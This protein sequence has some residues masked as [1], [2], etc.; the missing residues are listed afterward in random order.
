[1]I[2]FLN[3]Q[4]CI[5]QCLN[6]I[7]SSVLDQEAELENNNNNSLLWHLSQLPDSDSSDLD[8]LLALSLQSDGDTEEPDVQQGLWTDVW[9]RRLGRA[10]ALSAFSSQISSANNNNT[11]AS[12]NTSSEI[13][14]PCEFCEELFPEADLILH[15]VRVKP[16][17]IDTGYTGSLHTKRHPFLR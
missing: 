3:H 4:P 13:M 12:T 1:M 17:S 10:P 11:P 8:Y 14:L 7:V 6:V 2:I 5:F 9:D 15:Q 16:L